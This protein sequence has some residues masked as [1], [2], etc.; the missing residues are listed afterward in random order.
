MKVRVGFG[1][2]T[3]T[4]V[5]DG[6]GERTAGDA[7]A[8]LA[9]ALE[10]LGFDSLW[11]SERIS[12]PAPDPIVAM[13]YAAART[14]RLKFGTSVLVLPGRNPVVL[15]KAL[16]SLDV[17]SGG[18]LLPAVGLGAVDPVEQAAF[19]V[20][21]E[22]RGRRFDEMLAIMRRCWTDEVVD[23]DGEHFSFHGVRVQPKPVQQPLD[24][25][26]GGQ[27]PSELRRCG[28]L[29]DGWLPSFCDARDVAAGIPAIRAAAEE[30]GRDIDPEHFGAL[31]A[32]ADG[33]LPDVVADVVRRR[34][35]DKAPEDL[36]PTNAKALRERLEEMIAVGASKF[37]VVPVLEPRDW[38]EA[39]GQLAQEVLPVQS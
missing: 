30:A 36:I 9:E 38:A 7:F 15:A 12:G 32:Y 10:D 31:V 16:A 2:G 34:R 29:G 22:G 13:T 24:V 14:R 27:A 21:R 1:L 5:L 23:H 6:D 37:V 19:G 33:G 8:Q 26:L 28:R 39:L 17:L 3:R 20:P 11:L 18:R 25:W 35:P 4:A